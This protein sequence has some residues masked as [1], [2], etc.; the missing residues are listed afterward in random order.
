VND[1]DRIAQ[2]LAKAIAE[3]QILTTGEAGAAV[4]AGNLGSFTTKIGTINAIAT[5]L[6]TGECLLVKVEGNWYATDPN[7]NRQVVRSSVD[8]FIQRKPKRAESLPVVSI[9]VGTV[10]KSESGGGNS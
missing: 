6:C 3:R 9:T 5:N 7:D 8:R 10:D 1:L 2:L 4:K